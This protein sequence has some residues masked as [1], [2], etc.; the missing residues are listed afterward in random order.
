MPRV[1]PGGF[2][3]VVPAAE[4]AFGGFLDGVQESRIVAWTPAGVPVVLGR[5]GA[6]ILARPERAL[7]LWSDAL[8]ERTVVVAPR[9]R[10]DAGLWD[11]LGAEL[12]LLDSAVAA[13][14]RHPEELVTAAVHTVEQARALAERRLAERW[15]AEAVEPL[16]VDGSVA[17]LGAAAHAPQVVGIVK[18]H[19]TLVVA[20]DELPQLLALP[21]GH[22]TPVVAF[23]SSHHR[24]AVWTW[25][26]RVRPPIAADPLF[27]LLRVEVADHGQPTERADTVSRWVL[28]ERTPL[29]LPDARWDVMPYGIARCELY[30]KRG[31]GLR[32]VT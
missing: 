5:V 27:G 25:Y 31:R 21:E 14:V 15:C 4:V 30:L 28:A 29:A 2:T 18:S 17:V 24:S 23:A 10:L 22:R 16:C 13:D 19:R 26:V 6:V 9:A 12:D 1:E 3:R 8:V 32:G 11:A 7:R 20:P